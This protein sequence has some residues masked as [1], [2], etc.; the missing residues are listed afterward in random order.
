MRLARWSLHFYELAYDRE[1]V[2]SNARERAGLFA[3]LRLEADSGASGIAEGTIKSTW[4]GV[5]PRSLRASLEEVVLPFLE[6]TNLADEAAVTASLARVPE[7]RLAKGM[8]STACWTMRAAAAGRPLWQSL[9]GEGEAEVCWTVTRRAPALMAKESAE[10]CARY[11]FRTLK[12]KGGQGIDTD[13]RALK[14]IRAAVGSGVALYVDANSA[15]AREQALDYVQRIAAAG[16]IVAEDPSPLVPDGHFEA[17]QRAAGIPI[18]V[19][20]ACTSVRDA[21]LFLAR[22]ARALSLKPGRV[23]M[24]ECLAIAKRMEKPDC[25]GA[26]GIYAESALGTL[27]NLQLPAPLPAEQTFF[28]MMPSQVTAAVPQIRGGRIRLP[29]EPD[30]SQLVDWKAVEKLSAGEAS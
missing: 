23:G 1:V 5:S 15:Y 4:S 20:S 10:Y 24:G 21:E 17:L 26:V 6:Q 14:E 18:L 27:I 19:D 8:V 11:G 30:L 16:A 9:G 13:L 3:L 2:W 7:N 12:V 29:E 28:L 25:K 22:G